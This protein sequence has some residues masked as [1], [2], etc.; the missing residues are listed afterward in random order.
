MSDH[1]IPAN[2]GIGLR[3]EHYTHLIENKPKIGWIEVH[4]ENYFGQ[5]G[6]A[7]YY[8]AKA[9]ELY[10]LSLHGVGLSLGSTD[11]LN[12]THLTRLKALIRQYNPGLVSEHLSWGSFNGRYMNDLLPMPYT[13]ESLKHIS[14]RI[15]KVQEFLEHKILI[16]NASSYLEFTQSDIKEWDF[17]VEVATQSQCGILLDINNIYVNS[18]NHAFNPYEYILAIPTHLVE[19]IHLAG[20]TVNQFEHGQI[21]IDSHNQL[22]CDD[23]WSLYQFAI[24]RFG[25]IPSLIEW[26][27]DMPAL[28]ILVEEAH[29]ANVI[30]RDNALV[31][32]QDLGSKED[33]N[34]SIANIAV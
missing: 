10:P 30:I 23:V 28:D 13:Q 17:L 1:T 16:E 7:H 3:A 14:H 21:L 22:V 26:D 34:E 33:K 2:A 6:R 20:H 31:H 8:L 27:T 29:R 12:L 19:E 5:G 4:S 15:C 25:Q 32:S 18:K 11:P 9:R 24:R